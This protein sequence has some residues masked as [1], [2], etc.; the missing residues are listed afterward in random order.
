M[1]TLGFRTHVLLA[2][3]GV[4]GVVAALGRP[5]YAPA[6][7]PAAESPET[8]DVHGPLYDLLHG[9]QRW[10]TSAD[11]TT[12]WDV[13]GPSGSLIAGLCL[14]VGLCAAAS[15]APAVQGAVRDPLRYGSFALLGLCVWRAID[16]PG[17]NDQLEL[18]S[19]AL[20]ALVCSGMAWVC[21]QGVANA[22]GRRKIA[23]PRY[24]PPPPPVYEA[25]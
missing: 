6:P 2:V 10:V 19:G 15:L 25:R 14:V 20:V 12:G 9:A 23:P 11:G 5:W 18:R 3:A 8:F 24:T 16:S 13:L 21:A 22:P 17:P 4:I 1:R 7:R